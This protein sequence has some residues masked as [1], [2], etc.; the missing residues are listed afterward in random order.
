MQTQ[1]V[2]PTSYRQW[3]AWQTTVDH[4][5]DP[6]K[7]VEP[8]RRSDSYRLVKL[9]VIIKVK[10]ER[11]KKIRKDKSALVVWTDRPKLDQSQ[12]VTT[13]CGEDKLAA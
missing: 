4:C 5:I 12:T 13:V 3:L 1:N 10:K 6:A 11:M 9:N 8:I 7:G 2:L